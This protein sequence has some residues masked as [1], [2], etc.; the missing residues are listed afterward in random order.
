MDRAAVTAPTVAVT[1]MEDSKE[2][3]TARWRVSRKCAM[4]KF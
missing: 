4:V 2:N 1:R 3:S